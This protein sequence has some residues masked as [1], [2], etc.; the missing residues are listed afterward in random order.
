MDIEG[1]GISVCESLINSGLVST[2]ADLYSLDKD[3]VAAL[4]RMGDKSAANLLAAIENSKQ[5]G[6]ARL[7]CALG[8]R[9]VGTKAAKVLASH[10]ASLDAVMAAGTE[11]LT[12][13]PDI[14]GI[15]AGFITEF[16]SLPQSRHL[17]GRL[18]EAGVDFTSHEEK[19]DDRFAGQTFVLTGALSRFTRDEA[20]AIIESFGGKASG[21]VSKKTTYV[22]AG[23]NAGSKLTKAE[24]LGIRILTEAEF[25]EMIR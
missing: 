8:I 10:F 21:S 14:G 4:E 7:L 11:E 20:S 15:T 1:L 6:L 17:I 25:E 24:S 9:Q 2:A 12:A 13:I 3:A 22:L 18:R 23:E 19:K 5:A 16:F